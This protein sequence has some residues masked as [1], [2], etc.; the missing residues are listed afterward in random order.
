M[1]RMGGPFIVSNQFLTE[2][3]TEL[4]LW[5]ELN[6]HNLLACYTED[7][8]SWQEQLLNTYMSIK[9]S[10]KKSTVLIIKKRYSK[11]PLCMSFQ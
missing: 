1:T 9:Y 3:P 8:F 4:T 6:E 11:Y 5:T 2:F 10:E 7:V